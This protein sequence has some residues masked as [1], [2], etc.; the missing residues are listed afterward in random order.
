[1]PAYRSKL[2][3]CTHNQSSVYKQQRF[4]LCPLRVKVDTQALFITVVLGPS[5]CGACEGFAMKWSTHFRKNCAVRNTAR[6]RDVGYSKFR[7]SGR[8]GR[9]RHRPRRLSAISVLVIDSFVCRKPWVHKTV[10]ASSN[11]ST[12]SSSVASTTV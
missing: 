8:F 10:K 1:M 9:V 5:K 11:T 12:S 3:G 2:L 7:T 6:A 4:T